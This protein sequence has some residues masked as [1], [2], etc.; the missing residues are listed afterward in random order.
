MFQQARRAFAEVQIVNDS[1]EIQAY[2]ILWSLQDRIQ[3][4]GNDEYGK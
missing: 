2:S 4:P 3:R 1:I